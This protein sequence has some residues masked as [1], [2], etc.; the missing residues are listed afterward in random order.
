MCV[1][2]RFQDGSIGHDLVIRPVPAAA[3]AASTTTTQHVVYKR[4]A[5][6]QSEESDFGMCV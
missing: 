5:S 2:A 6:Q 3:A 4:S 1:C